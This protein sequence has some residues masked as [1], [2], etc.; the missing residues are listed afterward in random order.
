MAPEQENFS[1]QPEQQPQ[2]E[3]LFSDRSRRKPFNREEALQNALNVFW[4][5]GYEPTTVA[6]LC[7]AMHINPPSLY[8]RYESK[9]QLFIEAVE[10]YEKKYW[11]ASNQAFFAE[12]D[13][14]K[15]V[16][17]Y[18]VAAANTL[19]EGENPRG[20]LVVLAA[21]NVTDEGRMVAEK[22]R[23]HRLAM[24]KL[25]IDRLQRAVSEGQLPSDTDV[26]AVGTALLALLEGL[27]FLVKD[28]ITPAEVSAAASRAAALVPP[29]PY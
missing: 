2:Q 5:K 27:S 29:K 11:E 7:R 13:V 19:L 26:T 20:C 10:Y 14:H 23:E 17:D 16:Y 25:F 8:G 18:F 3:Q 15:A 22:L 4:Q 28:R 21:I 9:A 24:R 1:G 12:P 6:E